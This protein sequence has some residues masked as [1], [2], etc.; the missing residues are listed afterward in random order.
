MQ[1]FPDPI[2]SGVSALGGIGVNTGAVGQ[3]Y[4]KANDFLES[5]NSE[6]AAAGVSPVVDPN[7]E[8]GLPRGFR[9]IQRDISATLNNEDVTSI[10]DKL[11]KRGVA[12]S[13]LSGIEDL[14]NGN[15]SPT[16]GNVMG[17]I[18]GKGRRTGDMTDEELDVLN[19]ALQKLQLSPEEMDEFM[20]H[21]QEGRGMEGMQLL[22]GKLAHLGQGA[23][24]LSEAEAH[25]LAR[26]L[27]LSE[28][29][30]KK[31]SAL[32]G[33]SEEGKSLEE[34]LGPMTEDLATTRAELEKLAAEFKDTI[35]AT[36]REKRL[37]EQNAPVADARGS[38]LTERAERRM[39]DDLSAK[40]VGLGKTPK[41][42]EEEEIALADEQAAY[43]HE[44]RA[45]QE[46]AHRQKTI[47]AQD[48][49]RNG[50]F[51]DS[52]RTPSQA[53]TDFNSVL[54]RVDAASGMTMPSQSQGIAPRQNTTTPLAH[55]QE[56]YSQVEQGLLRQL[57][58]GTRQMTLQLNPVELGQLTLILSVRA[59]EVKAL[60]RA[61]NPEATAALSDQMAQLKTALEEQ[62]LKV[63]QLDVETQLPK[64]TTRDQWDGSDLAQFNK[65]QEMRERE[66]F[67]RLAKIRQEA[68]TT[69]AQDMQSTDMREE[70]AAS[71]LH[72][73]A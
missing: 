59:G 24:G 21:M 5:F 68:G 52:D 26:A 36:L 66:R 70:I 72:I 41:E 60:I 13:A 12:D 51:S 27:D 62:G 39:R 69:L 61:D 7:A 63:A 35:N 3:V 43:H 55:R 34:L 54:P 1:F 53:K 23:F 47:F 38:Q 22:K 33:G 30:M 44:Q 14:L 4:A 57:A 9:A 15:A 25:S 19:A 46:R 45:D 32:F 48:S 40:A 56:I 18:R 58:D 2:S 37:R 64:D 50:Q 6:L 20:Q 65:E 17:A 8:P 73:I 31:L 10:I 71:G 49:A 16:I 29:A 28:N 67:Q 11:R 42:L